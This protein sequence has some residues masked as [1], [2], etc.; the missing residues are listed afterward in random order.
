MCSST[1]FFILDLPTKGLKRN[2]P[3]KFKTDS[4]GQNVDP[5]KNCFCFVNYVM[6]THRK[7]TRVNLVT[8]IFRKIEVNTR[9]WKVDLPFFGSAEDTLRKRS[10]LIKFYNYNEIVKVISGA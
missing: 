9:R 8:T 6:R 4:S 3:T 5:N 2:D 7:F 1:R 10:R